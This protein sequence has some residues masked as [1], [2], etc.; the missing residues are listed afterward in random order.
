MDASLVLV[1]NTSDS[2]SDNSDPRKVNTTGQRV[3]R[4]NN[5]HNVVDDMIMMELKADH[6]IDEMNVSGNS[7]DSSQDNKDN[8]NPMLCPP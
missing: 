2:T 6:D 4:D 5:S 8:V 7:Q 1:D 3:L